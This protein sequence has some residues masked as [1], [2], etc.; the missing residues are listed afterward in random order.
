MKY[1]I[2]LL[3]LITSTNLFAQNSIRVTLGERLRN[4][5]QTKL[6]FV[7]GKMYLSEDDIPWTSSF[8][9]RCIVKLSQRTPRNQGYTALSISDNTE[10]FFG[11]FETRK[12]GYRSGRCGVSSVGGAVGNLVFGGNW[13]E[14]STVNFISRNGARMPVEGLHCQKN[15]DNN[16]E[17]V[18]GRDIARALGSY[19]NV[20]HRAYTAVPQR[21]LCDQDRNAPEVNSRRGRGQ[22]RS[23]S[24]GSSTTR[25]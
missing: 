15:A 22:T 5:S 13:I 6:Y 21:G 24:R 4:I 19:A 12:D 17:A 10:T 16:T 25:D 8:S 1:L 7:G 20:N 9:P 3:T 23:R 11:L 18:R 14:K 2:I